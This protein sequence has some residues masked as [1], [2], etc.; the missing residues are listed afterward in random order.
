MTASIH[1]TA[2]HAT[3]QPQRLSLLASIHQIIAAAHQRRR[4][5]ALDDHLLE[6]IGVT[7]AQALEESRQIMWNAPKYWL[8]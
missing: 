7:R 2:A 3:C 4:L 1:R 5:R 6:D 8:S